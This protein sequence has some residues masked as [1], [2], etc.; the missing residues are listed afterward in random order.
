[1]KSLKQIPIYINYKILL[2]DGF[3]AIYMT[4]SLINS[5][6]SFQ[7]K[8]ACKYT[9]PWVFFKRRMTPFSLA[10]LCLAMGTVSV[11]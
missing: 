5:P 2:P 3:I 7:V 4:N 6:C 1:M 8:I 10:K 9:P 11:T